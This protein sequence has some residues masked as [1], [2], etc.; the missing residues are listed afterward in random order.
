MI[1]G[2]VG[3]KL[4]QK[5]LGVIFLGLLLSGNAYAK[6][7]TGDET[8]SELLDKGFKIIN[9][10]S[11]TSNTNM[12]MI[13]IFTLHDSS[14][15]KLVICSVRIMGDGKIKKTRCREK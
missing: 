9:E 6:E 14:F 15:D 8:I 4:M 13:K 12:S 2:L 10:V 11:N 1:R 7:L 5:I 3:L